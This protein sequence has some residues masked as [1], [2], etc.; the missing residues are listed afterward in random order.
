MKRYINLILKV[1]TLQLRLYLSAALIGAL[2]GVLIFYP[3]Y[4]FIYYHEH[5]VENTSSFDYIYG[6]LVESLQGHTP[7]KTWF[8]AKVGI[9]FGLVLAWIYGQLHRK[10]AQI[11]QL[12]DELQRDLKS[13]IQQGEGPLLEFK[14][15]FR[16]DYQQECTNKNLETA[17]IKTLAGFMN[18]YTGGTLLI[19]V[20]DEG[21]I[22]GLENDF[23]T[24]RRKDTDGYEQ[25][26]MTTI[27]STLGTSFCQHIHVLFHLIDEKYAC[28]IIITP[29]PYPVFFKQNKDAKFYLR[30]GGGTR[31]LNIQDAT[32]YISQRWPR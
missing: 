14:S 28:R 11:E 29:S 3:L 1:L 13:T 23:K 26:L 18:S 19:G 2:T 15:S 22:L 9:V 25:L 12:T 31:D 24:L 4:D 27:S 5:G 7:I 17:V 30:T 32:D 21:E 20:T 6:R 10:L 8:L 16:W